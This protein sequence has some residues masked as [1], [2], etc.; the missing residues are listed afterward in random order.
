MKKIPALIALAFMALGSAN[1]ERDDLCS[2]STPT[3]PRLFME[4]HNIDVTA[5]LK[6][7]TLDMREINSDDTLRV[8]AQSKVYVPLKTDAD[9]V[10][11]IF[12]INPESSDP[13]L[14]RT[15]TIIFNYTRNNVYVSRACGYKTVFTLNGNGGPA[16]GYQRTPLPPLAWMRTI[17]VDDYNIEFETDAHIRVLW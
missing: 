6:P 15:D 8:T 14:I 7:V 9:T 3:T 4:F 5:D 17:I 16:P 1:C 12:T 10:T 11:W 2:E 13:N